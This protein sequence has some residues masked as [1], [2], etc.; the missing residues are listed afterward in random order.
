MRDRTMCD[1]LSWEITLSKA[2]KSVKKE[3]TDWGGGSVKTCWEQLNIVCNS[4]V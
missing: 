2:R 3:L 1:V 4:V